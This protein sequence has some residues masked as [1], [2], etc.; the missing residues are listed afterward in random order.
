MDIMLDIRF[1]TTPWLL[2]TSSIDGITVARYLSTLLQM[3]K[4]KELHSLP[5]Q[6]NQKR[7][8]TSKMYDK[9]FQFRNYAILAASQKLNGATVQPNIYNYM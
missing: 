4:F 1:S 8:W 9:L 2:S 5:Y 6:K 3:N 7:H